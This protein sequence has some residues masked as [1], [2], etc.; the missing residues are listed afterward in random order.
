[1]A[2]VASTFNEQL[3]GKHLMAKARNPKRRAEL[4]CKEIDEIRG[5][6]IRQTMFAE[7]EMVIHEIAEAGEPLTRERLRAEYRLLIEAYFGPN[8]VIDPVLELEGLRIPH[9]YHAFY[10]YKY[11]TGLSAAIAL[12]R[13]VLNGGTQ[14]RDRYLR[15]LKSGGSKY[16][17]D[18]L[19]DAGVDLEDPAPVGAAMDRFRELVTE[20]EDLV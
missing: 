15:F 11:A 6:I 9:F 1:M 5:T 2:E 13:M 3:L 17:L 16:P 8:F 18:L 4:V 12:S 7:Y 19:R 14:E 20:L 10:V